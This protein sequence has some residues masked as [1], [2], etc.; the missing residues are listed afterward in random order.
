[1]KPIKVKPI[2]HE[3]MDILKSEIE[4]LD[5]CN[6]RKFLC[7]ELEKFNY[8]ELIEL[9]YFGLQIPPRN[10]FKMELKHQEKIDNQLNLQ[11]IYLKHYKYNT[12]LSNETIMWLDMKIGKLYNRVGKLIHKKAKAK[13]HW[14]NKYG[15]LSTNQNQIVI[16]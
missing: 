11:F 15:N 16:L 5:D 9:N 7:N 4:K 10:S 8:S 3:V 14:Q 13:E 12:N 2:R 6:F 1:M